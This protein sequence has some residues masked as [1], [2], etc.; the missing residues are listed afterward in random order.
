MN[1]ERRRL[2]LSLLISLLAHAL[3]L[4]LSFG[5]QGFGLPGL[6]FPWQKRAAVAP[7][8][9]VVL[10]PAPVE[11]GQTALPPIT[12]PH[13]M[14]SLEAPGADSAASAEAAPPSVSLARRAL[15]PKAAATDTPADAAPPE[16]EASPPADSP[17]P[18]VALIALERSDDPAFLVP[19]PPALSSPGG[20]LAARPQD[21]NATATPRNGGAVSYTHLTL[22]TICSV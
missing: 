1:A 20:V 2:S 5:G 6:V 7:D 12:A 16:A 18:A 4:S 15:I 14:D 3:L 22:P 19:P 10:R 17:V 13:R 9:H 8:L 11:N 21:S